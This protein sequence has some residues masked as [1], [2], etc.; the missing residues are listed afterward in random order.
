M[1]IKFILIYKNFI[2][3]PPKSLEKEVEQTI[4]EV[5]D[6][7]MAEVKEENEQVNNQMEEEVAA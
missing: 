6:E 4:I 7:E 3:N 1:I 5:K 2:D